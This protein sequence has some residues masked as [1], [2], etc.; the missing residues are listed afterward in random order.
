M[1]LN[2]PLGTRYVD[3]MD[4]D[5]NLYTP[6]RFAVIG[7]V[8]HVPA[9]NAILRIGRTWPKPQSGWM[10]E[11]YLVLTP[12][13]REQLIA[14]LVVQRPRPVIEIP[15]NRKSTQLAWAYDG[16]VV[17]GTVHELASFL[18]G[19]DLAGEQRPPAVYAPTV[20]GTLAP[21]A[22]VVTTSPYDSDDWATSTVTVTLAEG[23]TVRGTWHVDGRA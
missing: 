9:G 18:E 17:R 2:Y 21:V 6:E 4:P 8:E 15:E 22:Y 20:D 11:L 5:T 16:A 7:E 1:T 13:E 12:A 19:A 3:N 10:Q 14:D 23:V